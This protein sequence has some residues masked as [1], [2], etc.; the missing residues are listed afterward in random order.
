MNDPPARITLDGELVP[1]PR[2]DRGAYACVDGVNVW[3]AP[4]LMLLSLIARLGL[5]AALNLYEELWL[6]AAE[7]F[8]EELEVL[9]GGGD[10]GALPESVR[11]Q[12]PDER[13]DVVV[14]EVGGQDVARKRVRIADDERIAL[15]GP[16]DGALGGLVAHDLEELR[17][18]WRHVRARDRLHRAHEDGGRRFPSVGA[19]AVDRQKNNRHP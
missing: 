4:T 15:G 18:E 16:A 12:L 2:L 7:L 1:A 5:V 13:A 8:V 11:V 6:F 10:V 19:L 14:L 3:R 17:Q 9:V